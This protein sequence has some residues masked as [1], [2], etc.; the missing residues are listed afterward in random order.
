MVFMSDGFDQRIPMLPKV[1]EYSLFTP[2]SLNDRECEEGET[3]QHVCTKLELEPLPN[4]YGALHALRG[5]RRVTL[6]T[7]DVEYVRK[8]M[9]ATTEERVE[10]ET[11]HTVEFVERDSWPDTW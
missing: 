11:T 2:E 1:L 6:L 5:K 4:G 7:A 9:G 3:Y 10:L 8:W